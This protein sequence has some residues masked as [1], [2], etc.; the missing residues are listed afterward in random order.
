MWNASL[1]A[2]VRQ[3]ELPSEYYWQLEQQL[4]VSGAQRVIFVCSD[5]TEENF[6]SMEYTPVPGRADALIAGWHQ[7]KQ[8]LDSYEPG[9]LKEPPQGK[10]IMR[11]P[12]LMVEIEGAVKQSNLTVYQGKALAFIESINTTLVTDQDFADAEETVK[13]CDK[14][15]SELDL[16]KQQALSQTVEID[17]LF[18]TIDILREAMRAKRLELTKLVKSRKEEIRAE[19]ISKAKTALNEHI[20]ALNVQLGAVRLPV[21]PVDFITAIKGKKTLTSLQ[22]AANDELARAKIEANQ[23]CDKYQANLKLFDVIEPAFK[24]L[25]ADI[26]QLVGNDSEHLKLLIDQRISNQKKLDDE[27]IER[28]RQAAA[29]AQAAKVAP[30]TE[31]EPVANAPLHSS[32]AFKYPETLGGAPAVATEELKPAG[33]SITDVIN[34]VKAD[35][36]AEGI[37]ISATALNQLIPAIIAGRIRHISANV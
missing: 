33:M 10:S 8:D 13:F 29:A 11:L 16:I 31:P 19:I 21:I 34:D 2:A 24:P 4:L 35:L 37:K 20:S 36:A 30:I 6:A 27:R 17:V 22:G 12:A 32:A 28:E 3:Q 7:F 18:R 25:F 9:E 5:G 14:A 1:A 26:N 23:I 15:E